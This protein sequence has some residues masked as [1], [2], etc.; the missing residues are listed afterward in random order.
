MKGDRQGVTSFRATR[1]H[2]PSLA[3]FSPSPNARENYALPAFKTACGIAVD[4]CS[5]GLS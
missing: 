4:R 5:F 2:A 1:L 3:F